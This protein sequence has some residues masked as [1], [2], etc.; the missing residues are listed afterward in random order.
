MRFNVNFYLERT[1]GSAL[2]HNEKEKNHT[3]MTA[4]KFSLE[5]LTTVQVKK[6]DLIL[7]IQ[8]LR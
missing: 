4:K 8:N 6:K 3:P 5:K 1:P 2:N 7:N